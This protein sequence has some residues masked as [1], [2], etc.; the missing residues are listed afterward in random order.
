MQRV[1]LVQRLLVIVFTVAVGLNESFHAIF[2]GLQFMFNVE[3]VGTVLSMQSTPEPESWRAIDSSVVAFIAY[4]LIW[5]AHAASGI[6]CLIGAWILWRSVKEAQTFSS[7]A[8]LATAGVGIGCILYLLGFQAIA[9]GWFLL[10]QAPTP[11]NF[12][13]QAQ[14][15]FLSYGAVL[16]YLQIV[17]RQR[18]DD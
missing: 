12:I 10:Y 6:L 18:G 3:F 5:L 9:G 7:S 17:T 14:Q 11:P 15:L 2:D 16:I 13:P 4:A 8:T 1:S